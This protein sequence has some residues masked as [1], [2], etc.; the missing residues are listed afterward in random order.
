MEIA[1]IIMVALNLVISSA[2]A[3]NLYFPYYDSTVTE[4][5][6]ENVLKENPTPDTHAGI[7]EHVFEREEAYDV[8]IARMKD[9]MARETYSTSINP[10]GTYDSPALE[11]DPAVKNLPHSII[12]QRYNGSLAEYSE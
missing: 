1:L 3:F 6:T 8:R 7:Q 10:T 2:I 11:L 9:E 12:D 4:T 5:V